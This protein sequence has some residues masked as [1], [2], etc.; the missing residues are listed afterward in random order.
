MASGDFRN[1]TCSVCKRVTYRRRKPNKKGVQREK[2]ETAK[3]CKH[4]RQHTP[5]KET[6]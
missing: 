2:I 3:F 5:H 1:F 6:S 4:C